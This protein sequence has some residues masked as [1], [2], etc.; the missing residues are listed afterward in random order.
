[1]GGGGPAH[2]AI[3]RPAKPNKGLTGSLN[4][5]RIGFW[6]FKKSYSRMAWNVKMS[7]LD[8]H[9]DGLGWGGGEGGQTLKI[10]IKFKIFN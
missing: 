2:H 1:M 10:N 3:N 4:Q 7:N 9:R 5:N 8:I 6:K